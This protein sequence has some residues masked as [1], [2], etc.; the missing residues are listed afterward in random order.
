ML[1]FEFVKQW[2]NR[3]E[4]NRSSTN[5]GFPTIGELRPIDSYVEVG[6]RDLAKIPFFPLDLNVVYDLYNNSDVLRVVI[7]KLVKETFRNGLWI[8][9]AFKKK[10]AV[11]K[12]EYDATVSKCVVCGS[13]KLIEPFDNTKY[14]I[15]NWMKNVNYNG[16]SLKEVLMDI[17]YDLNLFDNAYVLVRKK[18]VFNSKGEVV[19]AE[20][21]ELLRASPL[22]INLVMDKEGRL[23]RDDYGNIVAFCPEHREV[24]ESV[25]PQAF[26]EGKAKCSICGKKLVPAYYMAQRHGKRVYYTKGEVL[27][28]KKFTHGVGYGYPMP[29]TLYAKL[30]ILIKMD[31]FILWAYHLQ[32]S[33]YGLLFIKGREEDIAR[34]WKAAKEEARINPY[35]VIPIA[36]P[37]AIG[38]RKFVEYIDLSYKADDID[39]I[40]FRNELRKAVGSAFGVSPIFQADTSVGAGLSN[41][42]LQLTVTNRAVEFEQSIFNEK[43]LPWIMRQY[44]WTDWVVQLVH[45]EEKD[46]MA[47][48][49]RILTRIKIAKELASM[50]YKP[51][52]VEKDDGID[53]EYEYVGE[54]I[55]YEE[56]YVS[57]RRPRV[58]EESERPEGEPERGRISSRGDRFEGEPEKPRKKRK[59][60]Y[61]VVGDESG[62]NE[63]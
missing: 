3:G 60:A 4:V 19:G 23:G 52:M 10:C 18:Y 48:Y 45:P 37:D 16:Q 43:I 7:D 6:N 46:L 61:R 62:E 63:V 9:P 58:K 1:M 40:Q 30:M 25:D 44:G 8:K 22:M 32:R 33:P 26:E 11:C 59:D 5:Y 35:S 13:E 55:I 2:F 14:K 50:G 21:I 36:V 53:F 42:G 29:F 12:T 27:H 15:L 47:K 17:D 28:V 51:K 24:A 56:P 39:F 57:R 38:D 54:P 49:D 31:M 34:S 20:P 41:E